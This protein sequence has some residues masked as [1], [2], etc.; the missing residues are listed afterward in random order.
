[1]REIASKWF[2]TDPRSA[3]RDVEREYRFRVRCVSGDPVPTNGLPVVSERTAEGDQLLSLTGLS[4]LL[5][6]VQAWGCPFTISPPE[7]ELPWMC[8]LEDGLRPESPL[9]KDLP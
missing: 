9:R 3:E 4:E 6:C 7:G 1:M 2:F 8:E 5:Q